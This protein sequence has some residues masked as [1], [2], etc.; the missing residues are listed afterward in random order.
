MTTQNPTT[1]YVRGTGLH[2]VAAIK[3][4]CI[5]DPV[6]HCWHWQGANSNGRPRIYTIDLRRMEKRML[7]GPLALWMIAHGEVPRGIPYRYCLVHDCANPAH[8]QRASS[9]A[10]L[11]KILAAKGLFQTPVNIAIRKANA[12]I[13]RAKSGQVDTPDDVV[14][15]I[16]AIGTSMS[17][18]EIARQFNLSESTALRIRSRKSRAEVADAA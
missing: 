10:E 12:A 7:D 17:G 14:R 9:R 3:S 6:T 18:R 1:S 2:T 13:A 15:A 11:T 16:R 5:V 8:L 4:H